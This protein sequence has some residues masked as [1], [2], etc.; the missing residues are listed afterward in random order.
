[1]KKMGL[2]SKLSKK[3]RVTTDASHKF[4]PLG[5]FLIIVKFVFRSVIVNIT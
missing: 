1:M 4:F 3:F 5:N 2:R